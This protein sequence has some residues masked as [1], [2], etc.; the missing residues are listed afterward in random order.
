[1]VRHSAESDSEKLHHIQVVITG[2]VLMF[3]RIILRGLGGLRLD[4]VVF[5][6]VLVVKNHLK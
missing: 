5:G 2:A 3:G 6:G 1:M 4:F